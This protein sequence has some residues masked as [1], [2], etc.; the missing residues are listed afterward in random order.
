LHL[1][2]IAMRLCSDTQ[3]FY[4]AAQTNVHF[5]IDGIDCPDIS[6]NI[7][8]ELYPFRSYAKQPRLRVMCISGED[9]V[10]DKTKRS[11]V[12]H[13]CFN[14]RAQIPRLIS[15]SCSRSNNTLIESAVYSSP[16]EQDECRSRNFQKASP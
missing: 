2:R 16:R 8:I 12:A 1:W 3:A 9:R 10:A 7:R 4:G 13:T 6:G 15:R 14:L 5:P 11:L